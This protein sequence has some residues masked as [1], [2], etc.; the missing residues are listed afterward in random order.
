MIMANGRQTDRTELEYCGK[1]HVPSYDTEGARHYG[2]I[3]AC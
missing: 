2:I 1:T 3:G